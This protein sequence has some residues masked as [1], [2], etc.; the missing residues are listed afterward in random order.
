MAAAV[1]CVVCADERVSR[2]DADLVQ[3]TIRVVARKYGLPKSNVDRHRRYHL[4]GEV[5]FLNAS[6]DEIR[7]R[8]GVLDAHRAVALLETRMPASEGPLETPADVLTEVRGLFRKVSQ[9]TSDADRT[10]DSITALKAMAEAR[11]LLE[12]FGRAFHMFDEGGVTIDQ[13]SKVINV[14][15]GMSDDD[16]R[17]FL[18]SAVPQ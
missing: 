6:K 12:L 9:L 13:S 3:T 17:R 15:N 14:V 7:T 11:R 5:A 16:I 4:A 2:I 10:G 8:T 1:R 18:A